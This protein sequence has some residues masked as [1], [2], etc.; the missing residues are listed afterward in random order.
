MRCAVPGFGAGAVGDSGRWW[1]SGRGAVRSSCQT[2]TSSS[3]FLGFFILAREICPLSKAFTSRAL[4]AS[5]SSRAPQSHTSVI[6]I[7]RILTSAIPA[8]SDLHS[9]EACR[10][11]ASLCCCDGKGGSSQ[12]HNPHPSAAIGRKIPT[13][14][15]PNTLVPDTRGRRHSRPRLSKIGLSANLQRL[16]KELLLKY[17]PVSV[18]KLGFQSASK[19]MKPWTR[20]YHLRTCFASGSGTAKTELARVRKDPYSL[21]PIFSKKI[22]SFCGFRISIACVSSHKTF[23]PAAA[24]ITTSWASFIRRLTTSCHSSSAV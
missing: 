1:I 2:S 14:S 13:N 7:L 9:A 22:S 19:L 12:N 6:R 11:N 10:T 3:R 17:G 16:L 20:P 23:S 5:A 8:L 18:K 15:R 24:L 21:S 4:I